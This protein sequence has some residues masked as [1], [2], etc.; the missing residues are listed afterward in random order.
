MWSHQCEWKHKMRS[1]VRCSHIRHIHNTK[2]YFYEVKINVYLAVA[3]LYNKMNGTVNFSFHPIQMCCCV[4]QFPKQQQVLKLVRS[5]LHS[6]QSYTAMCVLLDTCTCTYTHA[7]CAISNRII[8]NFIY[9]RILP[10]CMG[11]Y[12]VCTMAMYYTCML[13]CMY[14]MQ[15]TK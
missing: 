13:A 14:T 5:G 15:V 9:P 8:L 3:I 10:C 12:N 2:Y 1:H 11:M 7:P 4:I 6:W